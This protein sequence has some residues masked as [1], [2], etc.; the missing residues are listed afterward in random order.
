[1][2]RFVPSCTLSLSPSGIPPLRTVTV[3]MLGSALFPLRVNANGAAAASALTAVATVALAS[4]PP[5]RA[6][7]I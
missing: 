7:A 5:S 4:A 1:M 6:K 3:Q 2:T